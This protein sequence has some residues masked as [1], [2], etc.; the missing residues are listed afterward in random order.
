MFSKRWLIDTAE[1][2]AV[3]FAEVFVAG[4]IAGGQLDLSTVQ[5]AAFA[6]LAAALAVVK[7][8]LAQ[9]S[10]SRDSASLVA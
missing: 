3:T 10:G 9:L 2:V 1:R 8:A 7:A 5:T 4:L 6:G